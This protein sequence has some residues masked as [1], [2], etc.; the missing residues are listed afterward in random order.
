MITATT[1][2]KITSSS[3]I[4]IALLNE[5]IQ[6]TQDKV[7]SQKDP[8]IRESLNDLLGALREERTGYMDLLNASVVKTAA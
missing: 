2:E 8:F 5:F 1:A 4:H 6:L 7:D 3:Q